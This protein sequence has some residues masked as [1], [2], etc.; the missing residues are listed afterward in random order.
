[1]KVTRY[2]KPWTHLVVDDFIDKDDFAVL[3]KNY[4]EE[5]SELGFTF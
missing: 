4:R 2:D 5:N 3:S 1:M